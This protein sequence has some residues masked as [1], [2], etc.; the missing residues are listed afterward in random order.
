MDEKTLF[1]S[2]LLT[3]I[4]TKIEQECGFKN[5]A[6]IVAFILLCID[7]QTWTIDKSYLAKF[8]QAVD[9]IEKDE[10][11]KKYFQKNKS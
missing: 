11:L 8:Y 5:A 2:Q 7:P 1:Q 3:E 4:T 6:F 9:I 10:N